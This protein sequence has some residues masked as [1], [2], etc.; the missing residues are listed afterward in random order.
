MNFIPYLVYRNVVAHFRCETAGQ[1]IWKKYCL[2]VLAVIS[3][4]RNS[5]RGIFS[6]FFEKLRL[7]Y[8]MNSLNPRWSLEW[9]QK[10]RTFLKMLNKV[11]DKMLSCVHCCE[12]LKQWRNMYDLEDFNAFRL[13]SITFFLP[14]FLSVPTSNRNI[15]WMKK[16]V[17]IMLKV[18]KCNNGQKAH[19]KTLK[20]QNWS[21]AVIRTE[22]QNASLF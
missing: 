20:P 21:Y 17:R 5:K 22:P 14:K 13:I 1:S 15:I 18:T 10:E 12:E 9:N 8:T 7:L 4:N 6:I 19:C 2:I 16:F 11:Y 3:S